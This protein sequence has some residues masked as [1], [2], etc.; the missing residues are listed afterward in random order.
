M[1]HP[2]FNMGATEALIKTCT[3]LVACAP[4]RRD[5]C[6]ARRC[7]MSRR[8]RRLTSVSR[9]LLCS[10]RQWVLSKAD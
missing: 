10:S 7:L 4:T 2:G 6:L 5:L 1:F 3:T 9:Q 8:R